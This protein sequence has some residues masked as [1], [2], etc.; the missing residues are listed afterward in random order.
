MR[1]AQPENVLAAM[2]VASSASALA[3]ASQ[4]L[5]LSFSVIEQVVD[6]VLSKASVVD[7]FNYTGP[8]RGDREPECRLRLSRG[9]IDPYSVEIR[10]TEDGSSVTSANVG[11]VLPESRYHVDATL[12][13][14]SIL[15]PMPRWRGTLAVSY[16]SGFEEGDEIPHTLKSIAITAAVLQ[17]NTLPSNPANREKLQK[18]NVARSVWGFLRTQAAPLERPRMAVSVPTSSEVS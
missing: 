14:V 17:L 4:A 16:T 13:V 15:H 11:E 5:D 10:Y 6:T 3:N 2:G 7:H 9:F 18:V 1:L 12:G 8:S